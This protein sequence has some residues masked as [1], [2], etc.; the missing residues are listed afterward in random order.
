[1]TTSAITILPTN[2]VPQTTMRFLS[3]SFTDFTIGGLAIMGDQVE[4]RRIS[5]RSSSICA[6][7]AASLAVSSSATRCTIQ[8]AKVAVTVPTR[9]MPPIINVTATT[10]P[11]VVTGERSPYRTVVTVVMAHHTASPKLAILEPGWS[12]SA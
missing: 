5:S 8:E 6:L 2:P 4:S 11:M 9:V 10:R 7:V 1:L 3:D 12:R